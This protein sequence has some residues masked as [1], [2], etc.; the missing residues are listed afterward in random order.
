MQTGGV[1]ALIVGNVWFSRFAPPLRESASNQSEIVMDDV[2]CVHAR[3]VEIF[4]AE[5][6]K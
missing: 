6:V 2:L 3:V 4:I 5:C 1:V